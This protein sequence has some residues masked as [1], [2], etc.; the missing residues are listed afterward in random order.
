M[1]SSYK[2]A[3]IDVHKKMLAVVV[4]DA[5]EI[6]EFRLERRKFGADPSERTVPAGWP[7][8]RTGR[9]GSGDGID[10]AVLEAGLAGAGTAAETV[11]G[12]GAFQ[13]GAERS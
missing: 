13:Q 10:R 2:V 3:G 6:G 12:A 7:A 1:E 8:G 4:T 5:A 9:E 11:S